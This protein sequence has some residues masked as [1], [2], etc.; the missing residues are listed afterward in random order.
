[1]SKKFYI[2][3]LADWG[4]STIISILLWTSCSV[5]IASKANST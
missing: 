4:N 5:S 2:V 1:M 3:E